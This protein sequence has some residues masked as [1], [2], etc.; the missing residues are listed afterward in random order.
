MNENS[1]NIR[2][3]KASLPEASHLS[4]A[5]CEG[6]FLLSL[7][8]PLLFSYPHTYSSLMLAGVGRR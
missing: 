6:I 1:E 4:S 8:L 3:I 2:L 5:Q 7:L